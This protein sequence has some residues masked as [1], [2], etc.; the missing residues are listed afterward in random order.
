MFD[1]LRKNLKISIFFSFR[2][3]AQLGTFP[4]AACGGR[5]EEKG[6][7]AVAERERTSEARC[8]N[9]NRERATFGSSGD[10]PAGKNALRAK[11]KATKSL[12]IIEKTPL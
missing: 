4:S 11:S 3:V 8:G 2:G 1:P 9:G 10:A 12:A 5:S 7:A 6:V